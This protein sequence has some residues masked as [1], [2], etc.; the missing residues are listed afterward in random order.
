ML[1]F[2]GGEFEA[3]FALAQVLGGG[4]MLDLSADAVRGKLDELGDAPRL[5]P[6]RTGMEL[7]WDNDQ[8]FLFLRVLRAANQD[9][10][11]AFEESTSGYTRWDAGAEYRIGLKDAAD[12]LLFARFK[13]IGDEEIRLST[14]FLRDVAPEAGRSLETGIRFS[15]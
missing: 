12:L 15:F 6:Y 2:Y 9:R 5:P 13:N 10:A 7:R 4:L 14:S 3:G 1:E 8:L 11:G